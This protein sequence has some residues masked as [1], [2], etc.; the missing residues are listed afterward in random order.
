MVRLNYSPEKKLFEESILNAVNSVTKHL[1]KNVSSKHRLIL[2]FPLKL[3]N[4]FNAQI[5]YL[6]SPPCHLEITINIILVLKIEKEKK[7]ENN[8]LIIVKNNVVKP[9]Y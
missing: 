7:K 6:V 8:L 2:L 9:Y 3:N 5:S 4:S 1:I